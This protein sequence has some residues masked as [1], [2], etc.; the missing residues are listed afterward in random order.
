[1]NRTSSSNSIK[2]TQTIAAAA[3]LAILG[4]TGAVLAGTQEPSGVPNAGPIWIC[5]PSHPLD[6][7]DG[8]CDGHWCQ[9]HLPPPNNCN[10]VAPNSLGNITMPE[11]PPPTASSD[12]SHCAEA[13]AWIYEWAYGH[14]D[15]RDASGGVDY[16]CVDR[17]AADGFSYQYSECL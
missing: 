7:I 2:K 1:M 5:Q 14:D 4:F 15:C 10:A 16:E 3:L 17:I 11:D 13:R 8:T 12:L 9:H 6:G